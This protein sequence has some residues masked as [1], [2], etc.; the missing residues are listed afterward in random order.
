M[1]KNVNI[2][3]FSGVVLVSS[4]M[5]LIYKKKENEIE[6][7]ALLD[8]IDKKVYSDVDPTKAAEQAISQIQT[9]K[10][11]LNKLHIG[12]LYGRYYDNAEIRNALAHQTTELWAAMKGVG[13]DVKPFINAFVQIKNKNTFAFID[14]LYKAKFGEGLFEAMSHE[15]ALNNT[16]YSV[17]EDNK[18]QLV[19]P[20]LSKGRWNPSISNYLK[21][22]PD[23]S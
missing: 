7:N 23:Y 4:I 1:S 12:N 2:A 22:L 17:Y 19:V 18:W 13:T 11:D 8:Y 6:V 15:S 21:N 20:F 14:R 5:F 10:I 16:A 3:I 9:M